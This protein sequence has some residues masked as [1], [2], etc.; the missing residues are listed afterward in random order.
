M[1][2]YNLATPGGGLPPPYYWWEAGGLLG[3]M[4]E[5][6]HHTGDATYNDVVARG[7]LSQAGPG[8]DFMMP[9]AEGNDDQAWFGLAAIAA[10]EYGFPAPPNSVPWLTLAQ[11]VFNEIAGRWD[12][13]RCN[14]GI[15]WKIQPNADG[16]HYKS[17]IANGL[18][19]QLAARLARFTKDGKYLDWA[20]KSFEWTQSVGLI[21]K[22]YNVFDGTDDFKT[23]GCPDV[24]HDQWSYNVG[25]FLYGAAVM[26][27]HTGD[28]KWADRTN[29]LVKAA[30]YFFENNVMLETRC[31]K[32]GSCNVDQQSFKAYLS[33]WLVNTAVL[34]PSTQ[35]T[36]MPW[37]SASANGAVMACNGGGNGRMC[38]SRWYTKNFDG[39]T[40]VGQQLAAMEIIHGLL[41][42]PAAAIRHP[43]MARS[44]IA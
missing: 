23:T 39:M 19:F 3:G 6:W 43:R 20:N 40:G 31:E 5:Y 28:S 44:F 4:V 12:Y 25:V 30:G 15:K 37:I 21:D 32:D 2:F 7:I 42:T 1:G 35:A 9:Q 16:W 34:Q 22:N 36:I 13:G 29:G 11:N 14:G 41:I 17:S 24:N 27:A 33:R 10:A 18:F 8:N 26:Q 38:G